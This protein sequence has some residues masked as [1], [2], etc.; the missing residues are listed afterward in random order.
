MTGQKCC[1]FEGFHFRISKQLKNFIHA[2]SLHLSMDVIYFM[3]VPMV[4]FLKGWPRKNYD[5]SEVIAIG[6]GRLIKDLFFKENVQ[7]KLTR[8]E[9]DISRKV[10]LSY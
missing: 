3:F 9:S 6:S 5:G 7:R 8:V 10:F 1:Q 4:F 2:L